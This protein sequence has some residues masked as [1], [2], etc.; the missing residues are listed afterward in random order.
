MNGRIPPVLQCHNAWI[1]GWTAVAAGN[2]T[3]YGSDDFQPQDSTLRPIRKTAVWT[4]S[5]VHS[6]STG[7]IK[8]RKNERLSG[9]EMTVYGRYTA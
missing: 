3:I 8:S 1:A 9:P 6:V 2:S 4:D 5:A 7:L